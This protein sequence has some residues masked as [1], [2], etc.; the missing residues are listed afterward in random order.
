M[1]S[2]NRLKE[3][4]MEKQYSQS[5]LAN[6]LKINRASYNKWETGK[7]VPNQKNLATLARILDVPTTY[8]ESVYKI[9]IPYLQLS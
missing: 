2:G 9:M 5:E 3:C 1:F 7:S 8:F 4:R 6:L